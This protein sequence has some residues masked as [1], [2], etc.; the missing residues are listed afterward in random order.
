[1]RV[2]LVEVLFAMLVSAPTYFPACF[3]LTARTLRSGADGHPLTATR[4]EPP[5]PL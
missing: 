1:M 5:K 4:P 2:S 3:R